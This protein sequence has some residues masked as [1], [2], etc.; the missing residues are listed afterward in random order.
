M[1]EFD[2]K[3]TKCFLLGNSKYVINSKLFRW[4]SLS[5]NATSGI[6]F[7]NLSF[8]LFLTGFGTI[9]L[10]TNWVVFQKHAIVDFPQEYPGSYKPGVAVAYWKWKATFQN[11]SKRYYVCYSASPSSCKRGSSQCFN[12]HLASFTACS[13][14]QPP[15]SSHLKCGL[16][17]Y[18]IHLYRK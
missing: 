17:Y 9:T 18:K 1:I 4:S 6:N 16:E 2:P 11:L 12:W 13:P 5:F 10:K 14:R 8:S 7:K 3:A 15:R